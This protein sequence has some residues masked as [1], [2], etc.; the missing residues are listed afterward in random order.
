MKTNMG[1]IDKAVRVLFAAV[2]GILYA[3]NAISGTPAVVL[4]ILAAI[5]VVTSLIGF[6]PLYV[7][8]GLSTKKKTAKSEAN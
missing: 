4:G 1:V 3:V 8:V 5:M 7:P 6:C 2:V